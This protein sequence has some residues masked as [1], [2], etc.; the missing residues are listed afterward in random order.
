M[1]SAYVLV[2]GQVVCNIQLYDVITF[3][4]PRPHANHMSSGFIPA[5]ANW[6]AQLV[7]Y[8]LVYSQMVYNIQLYI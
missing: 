5:L 1:T 2:Y 3:S 8:I 7:V 4:I 6:K